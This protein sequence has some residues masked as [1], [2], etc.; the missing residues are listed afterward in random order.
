VRNTIKRR[1]ALGWLATTAAVA[2]GLPGCGGGGASSGGTTG[3]V[4]PGTGDGT[5]GGTSTGSRFYASWATAP[6]DATAALPGTTGSAAQAFNNQTLRQVVRLSLGGASVRLKL[7]N[8]FGKAPITY[9]AVHVARSLAT[10][11]DID[12]AS[13]RAV[14]F[15]GQPSVTLAA[16]AELT[17]D[18]VTLTVSAQESLAV[19]MYFAG[20]TVVPTTHVVGRQTA[21]IVA[22]NQ[23]SAASTPAGF[24]DQLESYYGMTAVEASSTETT[25]VIVAFG[26][27]TMDGVASTVNANKRFPDQLDDRLKALGALR[28]GVVNAG[29]AGNRWVNDYAGPSGNSRFDRDVLGVTG[30][31]HTLILMGIN[32]IG[33]SVDPAPTQEVSAQQIIDAISGAAARAEARGVKVVLGTLLPYR[34]AAYYSDAGEVKRQAVNVWI[35]ANTGVDGVVDFDSVMRDPADVARLNPAYDSGDHL[36]P[37][38]AGYAAMAAAVDLSPV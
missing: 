13:D 19:S 37:N 2:A 36:H 1:V 4:N 7:S 33:F 38:D 18:P 21:Y 16:G 34:G 10:R 32:D 27:S 23:V 11:T 12:P 6:L 20:P 25:R 5:N 8:L 22:G 24:A 9:S 15:A 30:V 14:T 35:R 29:I 28:V 17:S 26:D 31:T 3:N